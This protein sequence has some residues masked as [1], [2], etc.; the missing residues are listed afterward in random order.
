MFPPQRRSDCKI[1]LYVR[2][3]RDCDSVDVIEKPIEI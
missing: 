1:N 3:Y 2:R